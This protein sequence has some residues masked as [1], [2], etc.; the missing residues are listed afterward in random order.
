MSME[1]TF[2]IEET[3]TQEELDKIIS[4]LMVYYLNVYNYH[5][6]LQIYFFNNMISYT[7]L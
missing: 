4:D 2:V 5:F 1:P 7:Q 3:K 6:K